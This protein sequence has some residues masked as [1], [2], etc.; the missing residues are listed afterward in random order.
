MSQPPIDPIIQQAAPVA[1][2]AAEAKPGAQALDPL[3]RDDDEAAL[4]G[5]PGGPL[6]ALYQQAIR[7]LELLGDPQLKDRKELERLAVMIAM[8]AGANGLQKIERVVP[9][10]DGL[11]YHFADDRTIDPGLRGYVA[12]SQVGVPQEER[13]AVEQMRSRQLQEQ[14]VQDQRT[15]DLTRDNEIRRQDAA[16]R[17]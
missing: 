8:R 6:H 5:D 2:A 16:R 12:Q 15:N 17:S 7:G 1:G 3:Q 13:V 14:R 11:G 4:L 9:S 10:G